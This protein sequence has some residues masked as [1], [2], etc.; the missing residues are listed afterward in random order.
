M[1]RRRQAGS[2]QIGADPADGAVDAQDPG[3]DDATVHLGD[4]RRG[5]RV[6][7]DELEVLPAV[8]QSSRRNAVATGS[9]SAGVIGRMRG[10]GMAQS[11]RG[12][13]RLSSGPW[14][15]CPAP[16]SNTSPISPGSG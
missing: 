6:G 11:Y 9:M 13:C 4:E 8:T 1:P 10:E 14:P 15:P 2:T 5:L 16:M 3:P 12:P 7:R